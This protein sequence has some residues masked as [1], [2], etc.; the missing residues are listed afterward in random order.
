M[1]L[2]AGTFPRAYHADTTDVA[3]GVYGFRVAADALV[4]VGLA[5]T[6]RA[7]WV[8]AHPGGRFLYVANEIPD[9]G[10]SAFAV[11]PDTGALR[12]LNS[13]PTAATPCHCTVDATGRYL[14]VSTFHG[15][16]VHLFP[17]GADG[18][19]GPVLDSRQ[20]EGASVHPRRQRSP[21][22]HSVTLDPENRFA[23]VPDLGTD[24]VVVYELG[25][26]KLVPAGEVRVAPG[27]GPRHLAFDPGGE[28][29]YL[30]NEMAATVT[31]FGYHAGN[32]R[33]LQTVD[34]LPEGLTGHRSAAAIAVHGRFLYA[35]T[36]SHGTSGPPPEPG[37]DS[38]VWFEIDRGRLMFRGRKPSGGAIPRSAVLR[39]ERLYVAHQ[40][41]GTI[42][43]FRLEAGE[44]V[45]AGVTETPVPVCLQIIE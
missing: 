18:R 13:R 25:H 35:T 6:P 36:R 30:V 10:V 22:P 7:G 41:S 38:V 24:R 12:P 11:D 3:F 29:V 23:L 33:E 28:F 27:S 31:A 42:V 40:G 5:E 37:L 15:G 9:G 39:G 26:D 44:P 19:I 16:T 32:L 1:F 21:H 2:Y 20:H 43:T 17:L 34:L 45:P 8:A 14:L 4:P